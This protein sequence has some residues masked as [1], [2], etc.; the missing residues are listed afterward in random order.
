MMYIRRFIKKL[1]NNT[2]NTQTATFKYTTTHRQ[3]EKIGM[4][5][6]QEAVKKLQENH[7]FGAIVV[8]MMRL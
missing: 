7:P 4:L 3:I 8:D 2:K 5:M 1:L 6:L